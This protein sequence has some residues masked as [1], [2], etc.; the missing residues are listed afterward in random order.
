LPI[1]FQQKEIDLAKEPFEIAVGE[2][3]T[4]RAGALFRGAGIDINADCAS[5][6]PGLFAAGDCSSV[7][8]AVAGAAV[9]GHVAG[10]NA[11]R[12]AQTQPQ[13][14]PISGEEQERIRET[15]Y[16]PLQK[17]KGILY[18]QFED[19]V[20][21]IVT[22]LIGYRRDEARLQEA[23]RR[24]YALKEREAEL[25]AADY[26][27]VMR[28]NEARSVRT[29]AEVLATSALA[30]RETRGGAAHYRVDYPE[31][32][33]EN[34]LR[35]IMVEQTGNGLQ[36]SSRPTNIPPTVLPESPLKAP[37]QEGL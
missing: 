9:M 23:Q 32:D 1:Y 3:A 37:E 34:F 6:I 36:T 2:I 26:H 12:Y 24:L 10:I 5:N 30:R 18:N 28:V 7:N 13:P 15:L 20:R 22:G 4:V 11:G 17:D 29:V 25:K 27:G 14:Q 16:D 33:D 31:R 8:A 35:I 21:A 19:E